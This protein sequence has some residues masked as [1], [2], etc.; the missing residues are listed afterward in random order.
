MHKKLLDERISSNT[1]PFFGS[2]V[3]HPTVGVLTFKSPSKKRF[4]PNSEYVIIRKFP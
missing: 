3:L 4:D 1:P 2:K